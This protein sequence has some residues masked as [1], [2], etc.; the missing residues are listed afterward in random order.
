MNWIYNVTEI[1]LDNEGKPYLERMDESDD[2]VSC[3]P[4]GTAYVTLTDGYFELRNSEGELFFAGK[5]KTLGRELDR[6]RVTHTL[7]NGMDYYKYLKS[8]EQAELSE[9]IE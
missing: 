5:E 6:I 9:A 1:C 2:V 8:L 4:N 7:C 3:F